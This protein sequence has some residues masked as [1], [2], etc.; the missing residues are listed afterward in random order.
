MQKTRNPDCLYI[1]SLD[2]L[3]PFLSLISYGCYSRMQIKNRLPYASAYDRRLELLKFSLSP[4]SWK[5]AVEKKKHRFFFYNHAYHTL[6][7]PAYSLFSM[8]SID[9]QHVLCD[10]V[11]LDI[12]ASS[13]QGLL[14]KQIVDIT[15]NRFMK[16]FQNIDWEKRQAE[17]LSSGKKE[18][19]QLLSH[20]IHAE[21]LPWNSQIIR[22]IH[23]LEKYCY[24][25]RKN[26]K[27][28]ISP[29]PLSNLSLEEQKE[30]YY[31]IT[32]YSAIFPLSLPGQDLLKTL[33]LNHS[34]WPQKYQV[35]NR[36]TLNILNDDS[37]YLLQA[38]ISKGSSISFRYHNKPKKWSGLPVRIKLD[39]YQRSY[40]IIQIHETR[41]T[42]KISCMTDIT[43]DKGQKKRIIS[44]ENHAES[45][46][47]I[48]KLHYTSPQ[49]H[50]A[51]LATI[52]DHYP[53]AEEYHQQDRFSFC[54]I[55]TEDVLTLVP[56][57]R[58]LHPQVTVV[59]DDKGNKVQTRIKQDLKEA[60]QNYD[61]LI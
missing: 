18:A 14:Q 32:F 26:K 49:T 16:A 42:F 2:I 52:Y 23:N 37:L 29:W 51:L 58:T 9:I 15:N 3:R 45:A 43:L 54:R 20:Y 28:Y 21:S 4:T 59:S 35:R 19:Y 47:V 12:I 55:R 44:K 13:P 27:Y 46:T 38:A 25:E 24:I 61:G 33:E 30:L 7:N 5:C 34:T 1:K 22:R 8:K 40:V 39:S 10:F 50:H 17:S 56:W 31:A 53:Y 41:M 36:N 11:I 60:L 48:L 6:A 57:L